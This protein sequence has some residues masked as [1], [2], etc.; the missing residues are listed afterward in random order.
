MARSWQL[1][2]VVRSIRGHRAAAALVVVQLG[3]GIAITV[4]AV[5][6]GDYFIERNTVSIG[7]AERDLTLVEV[8]QRGRGDPH[9]LLSTICATPDCVGAVVV[10]G[11]PLHAI[12]RGTDDVRR[13]ADAPSIDAYTL[14]A[15]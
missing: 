7:T 10:G 12:E 14:D 5:L 2:P 13:A 3:I 6:I 9:A 15:G 8:Q 11:L 1:G 4:L